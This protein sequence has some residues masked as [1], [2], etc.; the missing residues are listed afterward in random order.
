MV[1]GHDKH[2]QESSEFLGECRIIGY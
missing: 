2:E 1:L